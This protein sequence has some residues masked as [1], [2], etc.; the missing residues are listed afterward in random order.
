MK[1][2]QQLVMTFVMAAGI[3][4][5][6]AA[7]SLAGQPEGPRYRADGDISGADPGFL[8]DPYQV[9]YLLV[10]NDSDTA[11]EVSID[12]RSYGTLRPGDYATYMVR[13]GINTL[14]ALSQEQEPRSST[15]RSRPGQLTRFS[16][17]STWGPG[18]LAPS[19][20]I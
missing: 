3:V 1:T 17:T 6:A 2:C 9:G 11:Q 16:I 4:A 14:M 18:A 15:L 8:S 5:C 12:G 7:G 19:E 13:P 10:S 20:G